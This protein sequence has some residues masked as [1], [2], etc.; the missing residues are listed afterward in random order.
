MPKHFLINSKT[1][2]KKLK[3]RLFRPP[4]WPKMTP[5]NHQNKPFFLLNITNFGKSKKRLFRPPE[6]PK[7]TPETTK[8]SHFFTEDFEFRD[9]LSTFRAINTPKSRRFEVENNAQIVSKQLQ[10]K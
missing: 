3:K 9:H 10:N 5:E 1:N 8:I 7:M 4:K 2:L 6:W